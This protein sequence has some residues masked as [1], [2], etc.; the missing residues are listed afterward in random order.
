M[1]SYAKK[2]ELSVGQSEMIGTYGDI[3]LLWGAGFAQYKQ[4]HHLDFSS[5]PEMMLGGSLIGMISGAYIGKS[6]VYTKGDTYILR[7]SSFLGSYSGAA[8]ALMGN[9]NLYDGVLL[10]IACSGIGLFAGDRLVKDYDYSTKEG[11]LTNLGMLGGAVAGG[12]IGALTITMDNPG[13][14]PILTGLGGGVGFY[15]MSNYY[16]NNS[17]QNESNANNFQ[18]HVNPI[19]AMALIKEGNELN[20]S[21]INLSVNF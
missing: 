20:T 6:G 17:Q 16:K 14:F 12:S 13:L 10:S 19:G 8:L 21:I 4:K 18:F 15:I 11:I 9:M 1:R 7:S 2:Y 3:L 5:N